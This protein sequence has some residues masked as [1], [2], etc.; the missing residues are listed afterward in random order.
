MVGDFLML[1][2]MLMPQLLFSPQRHKARL[3]PR[4][5][6]LTL[7]KVRWVHRLHE[8]HRGHMQM[9]REKQNS[10]GAYRISPSI[11]PGFN[12]LQLHDLS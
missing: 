10:S 1:L 3:I 6:S 11:L 8:P 7:H 4:V 9:P 2:A 5:M 12:Y